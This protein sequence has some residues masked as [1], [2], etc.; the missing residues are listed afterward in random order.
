[1]GQGRPRPDARCCREVHL[2]RFAPHVLAADL[3][4]VETLLHDDVEGRRAP[5]RNVAATPENAAA[6]RTS[7]PRRTRA[8]ARSA[9]DA[10]VSSTSCLAACAGRDGAPSPAKASM[11]ARPMPRLPPVTMTRLVLQAQVHGVTLRP[12]SEC[13]LSAPTCRRRRAG[14]APLMYEASSLARECDDRG[15]LRLARSNGRVASPPGEGFACGLRVFRRQD[16]LRVCHHFGCDGRRAHRIDADPVA[17]EFVR[18]CLGEP[19]HGVLAGGVGA[20]APPAVEA[21]MMDEL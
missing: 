17:R 18:R 16:A 15:D 19:E 9:E 13:V 21:A 10:S 1:M 3:M 12:M 14:R 8:G 11:M 5:A 2:E 6:S 20:D 7:V 4:R